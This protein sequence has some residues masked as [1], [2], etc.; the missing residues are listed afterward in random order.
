MDPLTSVNVQAWMCHIV[1]KETATPDPPMPP[2]QVREHVLQVNYHRLGL[3][4]YLCYYYTLI[5]RLEW[6]CI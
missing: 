4:R 5:M 2:A 1:V 6:F 3:V